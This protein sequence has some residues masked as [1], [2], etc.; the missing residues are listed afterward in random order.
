MP[1]SGGGQEMARKAEALSCSIGFSKKDIKEIN[2]LLV[3]LSSKYS[4]A[5]FWGIVE[6][7]KHGDIVVVRDKSQDHIVGI[8]SVVYVRTFGGLTG[9]IED[10]VV[11]RAYRHE[12]LGERIVRKL[13]KKAKGMG[14]KRID[15]TSAPHRKAANALYIKLGFELRETNV[16]RLDL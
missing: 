10:V 6:I 2:S 7:L 1:H 5:C 8:G 16:Y 4:D 15:L 13:I 14:M 9:R 11:D 3:Q 12:G